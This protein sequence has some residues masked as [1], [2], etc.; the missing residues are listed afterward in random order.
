M[1]SFPLSESDL[2]FFHA[3]QVTGVVS[4]LLK[5]ANSRQEGK[6]NLFDKRSNNLKLFIVT[7]KC[8]DVLCK[9]EEKKKES[10]SQIKF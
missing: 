10:T 8:R 7:S 1:V 3:F 4:A 6:I 9:D 5:Q 2:P